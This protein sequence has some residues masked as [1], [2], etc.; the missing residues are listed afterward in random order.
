[1]AIGG[2]PRSVGAEQ[3]FEMTEAIIEHRRQMRRRAPGLAG[4]EPPGVKHDDRLPLLLQQIRGRQSGNAGADNTDIGLRI[5]QQFREGALALFR[6]RIRASPSTSVRPT[7]AASAAMISP[8]PSSHSVASNQLAFRVPQKTRSHTKV[9]TKKAIGNG[10][11]I[12]W[13]GCPAT[14]AVLRGLGGSMDIVHRFLR[15][16]FAG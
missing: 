3:S 1:M 10:I 6:L 13:I 5:L 14:L 15:L 9:A 12:G 7:T 8:A 2:K 11:S 4:R 16:G